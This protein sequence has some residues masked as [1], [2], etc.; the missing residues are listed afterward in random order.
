MK[1]LD[2]EVK[3]KEIINLELDERM[4]VMNQKLKEEDEL[5]ER[6]RKEKKEVDERYVE[7]LEQISLFQQACLERDDR[8]KKLEEEL[9]TSKKNTHVRKRKLDN[10]RDSS[11]DGEFTTPMNKGAHRR[12]IPTPDTIQDSQEA[13]QKVRPQRCSGQKS[14]VSGKTNQKRSGR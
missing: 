5:I 7:Q 13:K 9:E 6:I 4:K 8:I 2:A 3:K 14:Q 11:T 10:N 12:E 1:D